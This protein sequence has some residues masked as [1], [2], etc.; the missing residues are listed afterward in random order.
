MQVTGTILLALAKIEQHDTDRILFM[1]CLAAQGGQGKYSSNCCV[2][3]SLTVLLTN[4]A[5]VNDP[6]INWIAFKFSQANLK[7]FL[8]F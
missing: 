1:F 7:K 5:N 3:L 6:L 2:S 8:K 4:F